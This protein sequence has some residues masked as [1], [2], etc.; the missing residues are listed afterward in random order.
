MT[1]ETLFS[2]F[3]CSKNLVKKAKFLDQAPQCEEALHPEFL[4]TVKPT[5]QLKN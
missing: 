5:I 4:D 1:S 2:V 3:F